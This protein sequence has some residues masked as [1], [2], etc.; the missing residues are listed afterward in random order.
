MGGRRYEEVELVKLNRWDRVVGRTD[1]V[2]VD[3]ST[4]TSRLVS[5][6]VRWQN[7]L[8]THELGF[9]T[10]SGA[11]LESSQVGVA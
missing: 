4:S 6:D 11:S 3:A 7:W 2:L 9:F 1:E 8:E 10:A 5:L